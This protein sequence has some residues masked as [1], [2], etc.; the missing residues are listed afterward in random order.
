[1]KSTAV[2]IVLITDGA[3]FVEGFPGAHSI[4]KSQVKIGNA[5][6]KQSFASDGLLITSHGI[7]KPANFALFL[8]RSGLSNKK[9]TFDFSFFHAFNAI[10]APIPAGSPG[11]ITNGA[12]LILKA[13]IVDE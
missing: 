13:H 10:S 9:N 6:G 4:G 3:F 8:T 1:V 7:S 12:L 11:V 2:F 5:S